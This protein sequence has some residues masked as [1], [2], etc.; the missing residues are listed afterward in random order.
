MEIINEKRNKIK[1]KDL[2][3]REGGRHHDTASIGQCIG[4]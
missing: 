2:G 1:K 4:E 3:G